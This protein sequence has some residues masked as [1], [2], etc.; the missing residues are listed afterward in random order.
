MSLSTASDEPKPKPH[1][2][3]HKNIPKL[4]SEIFPSTVID[5]EPEFASSIDFSESNLDYIYK[6]KR[7]FSNDT[8]PINHGKRARQEADIQ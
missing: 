5:E 4:P 2:K 8:I 3:H 1:K 6:I 7:F